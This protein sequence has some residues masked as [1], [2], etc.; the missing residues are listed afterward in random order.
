M[1]IILQNYEHSFIYSEYE[2]NLTTLIQC[3]DNN[4]Q[5]IIIILIIIVIFLN[6]LLERFI[7]NSSLFINIFVQ[8]I[9]L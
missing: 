6:N 8:Y 7:N 2:N 9:I 4:K 5:Y 3:E 1:T